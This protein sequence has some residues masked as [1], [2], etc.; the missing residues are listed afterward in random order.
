MPTL[1][2]RL[3]PLALIVIAVGLPS[4]RRQKSQSQLIEQ[5]ESKQQESWF[6]GGG[7]SPDFAAAKAR[8]AK[9]GKVILAYFSRSYSP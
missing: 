1:S 4:Q 3:M 8:A 7:W 9:E 6:T 5:W 2:L